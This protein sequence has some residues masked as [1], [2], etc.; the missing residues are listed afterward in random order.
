[1][2]GFTPLNSVRYAD[3]PVVVTTLVKPTFKN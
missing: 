2:D 3:V 1:L